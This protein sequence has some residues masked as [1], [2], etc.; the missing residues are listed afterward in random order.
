MIQGGLISSC[1][2]H[3]SCEDPHSKSGL[4]H[5]P[6]ISRWACPWAS[7]WPSCPLNWLW[8]RPPTAVG[9]GCWGNEWVSPVGLAWQGWEVKVLGRAGPAT[10]T[11]CPTSRMGCRVDS[12]CHLALGF[13]LGERVGGEA[14][15]LALTHSHGCAHTGT[16]TPNS[17]A[18]LGDRWGRALWVVGSEG[19]G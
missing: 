2:L 7:N 18:H 17:K 12:G 10:T 6:R 11:C 5:G 8:F 3:D 1:P 19:L 15:T 13:L 9:M 4:S 16:H 14:C